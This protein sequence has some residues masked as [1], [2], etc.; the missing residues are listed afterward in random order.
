MP[1]RHLHKDIASRLPLD[2][3]NCHQWITWI[4]G[5]PDSTGKFE[6]FPIGKDGTGS[7]WQKQHQWFSFEDAIANAQKNHRSGVG[8]VLPAKLSDGNYLVALDF[9]GV[10]ISSQESNPRYD[11]IQQTYEDLNQPYAEESPSRKGLRM[12][13]STTQ[14]VPQVSRVNPL[15]GKDELFCASGRWVTVTGMQVGGSGI[16]EETDLLIQLAQSWGAKKVLPPK[17]PTSSLN[18][19]ADQFQNKYARLTESSLISVLSK[20]DCFDEPKWHDVSNALARAYGADGRDYFES[21][22]K[23]DYWN[24]PY[25]TFDVTEVNEKYDRALNEL[26]F[27]PDGFGVLHLIELAGM[28]VDK[29]EFQEFSASTEMIN[30]VGQ[31]Y[32]PIHTSIAFPA[33]G[34][35]KKPQQVIENLKL[36]MA[37]NNI[38]SRYNQIT[39]RSELLIPGLQCVKDETDNTSLTLMTDMAIKAGMTPNRVPELV[40]AIASQNPFC[41]VQTYIDSK[42]W[43]GVTRFARFTAQIVCSNQQ[44]TALLWRKWLIQA[45]AA[46]YER[47]GISNAGVIVLT[48]DQNIGKTTFFRALTSGVHGVFLEGQTLN[49]ADKDS[50]LAAVSHW[51]VELGELDATFKKAEIAQ[52]KAFVT[53]NTD[54]VRRPYARKDSIFPR[55]TVFAGTVNDFQFLHDITGNRRFWPIAVDA[56]VLDPSL[57][58]Q[59]LW[60]E[61]KTWYDSGEKWFLNSEELSTLNQYSE[62]FMVN[63]PDIEA[64]L[65]K[66]PFIGCTQWKAELMKDI[67]RKAFIDNPN[68]AQTMK[69]A[70]A[71][72][73]YNGGQ[74]P[75]NSNQ[76]R[77][78][79]VPDLDAI[80]VVVPT[81]PTSWSSIATPVTPVTP[82]TT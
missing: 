74:K 54:T 27:R 80:N 73:K 10:D 37:V 51:I 56:I 14:P 41:P 59:Q 23:G 3:I 7:A 11:E 34:Q 72:R 79:F 28:E 55:R 4:A 26:T 13:V 45:V 16:P 22:S 38:T 35:T 64:L 68:K 42:P 50:V 36:V 17:S 60:A 5:Q 1:T 43:D 66:Y 40:D 46:A 70:S 75:Q 49:P 47:T 53:K 48:G 82:V 52:L 29:V 77:R 12:F 67:C 39:K 20:I 44:F 57:D 33:I 2:L 30:G 76:G 31:K 78:H 18:P 32:Q 6:K 15:G 58:Y 21:F 9:D 71:I 25:K 81:T 24:T 8:V 69:L 65:S 63:D 19:Q 62:Q 61:V